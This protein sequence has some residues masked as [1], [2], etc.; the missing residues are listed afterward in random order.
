[1]ELLKI[2]FASFPKKR[3]MGKM[4][5][6]LHVSVQ[7]KCFDGRVEAVLSTFVISRIKSSQTPHKFMLLVI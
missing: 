4:T 3:D 5:N 7:M 2:N 1:M 6:F